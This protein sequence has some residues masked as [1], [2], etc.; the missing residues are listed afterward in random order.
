MSSLAGIPY[1]EGDPTNSGFI[2][3]DL[4][5]LPKGSLIQ[6]ATIFLNPTGS[7]TD[8]GTSGMALGTGIKG[9][10]I[11]GT[12]YTQDDLKNAPVYIEQMDWTATIATP[13]T[14]PFN[15]EGVAALQDKVG[16]SFVIG[17]VPPTTTRNTKDV[18]GYPDRVRGPS[19]IINYTIEELG[20]PKPDFYAEETE[21]YVKSQLQFYDQSGNFPE[22]WSWDFGDGN[23]STEQN[24]IHTYN[25][26]GSYTVSL[27]ATNTGGS[28]T[29][30]FENYITAD[31]P[32][33]PIADFIVNDTTP[34]FDEYVYFTDLSVGVIDS[35]FWD[36]GDG[37]TSKERN[38]E[39]I[40]S[41]TGWYSITLIAYGPFENDT[42]YRENY[43]HVGIEEL[44][45]ISDFSIE[46][47]PDGSF[48]FL[49]YSD[50]NPKEWQWNFGDGNYSTDQSPTHSYDV[51]KEYLVC[52]KVVNDFGV[53]ES[54][55]SLFQITNVGGLH[56]DDKV[57]VYPNPFTS[58]I[59]IEFKENIEE[60]D[61][62]QITDLT[63]KVLKSINPQNGNISFDLSEVPAGFYLLKI[64]SGDSISVQKIIKN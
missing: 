31:Y 14:S 10:P 51:P 36:F 38:T 29:A 15:L 33:A 48:L 56:T 16:G 64:N 46:K 27:T 57:L 34:I 49:D 61:L 5:D 12:I 47:Q 45:P 42:L 41:D 39:N 55:K 63:G 54:C 53:D 40:Y 50:N 59:T 4:T 18:V 17:I 9:N 30:T 25:E 43:L 8:I 13:I 20:A 44:K 58:K 60:V 19:V 35:F 37:Y 23:T 62:I 3:F 21:A 24:P 1:E 52:L 32:P 2:V 22:S 28:A 6:N 26:P 7:S 11:N